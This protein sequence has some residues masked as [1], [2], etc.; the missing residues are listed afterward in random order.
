MPA[1]YERT[2]NDACPPVAVLSGEPLAGPPQGTGLPPGSL[3][4][5]RRFES[6]TGVFKYQVF[7]TL[8]K[9]ACMAE[10]AQ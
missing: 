5:V 2:A 1:F 9:R 6:S 7:V 10:T 3:N 8:F 4:L